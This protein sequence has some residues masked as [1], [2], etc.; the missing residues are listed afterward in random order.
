MASGTHGPAGKALTGTSGDDVLKGG[1]GDDN[2]S[3]LDGNDFL[4]GAGG[5]DTLDG[6]AGND[7]LDG[8]TGSDL[9]TGGAGEDVFLVSGKV[10]ATE[11]GLDRIADFTTGVDRIGFGGSVSLA[12]HTA[13]TVSGDYATVLGLATTAITSGQDD[14]VFAQVGN[15]LVVF[16]DSDLRDTVGGAIVLVGKT[17]ADVSVWDL[18]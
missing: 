3:G 14:I 6:G 9:L 2:I 13:T 7:T 18:F 12:G 15:D 8:G 16:A 10:T 11:D 1:A 4:K 17:A 5:D